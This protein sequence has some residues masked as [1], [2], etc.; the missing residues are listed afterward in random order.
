MSHREQGAIMSHREQGAIMSHHD[1]LLHSS[2]PYNCT[3]KFMKK[4]VVQNQLIFPV[5]YVIC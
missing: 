4:C 1:V 3:H 2:A 5:E